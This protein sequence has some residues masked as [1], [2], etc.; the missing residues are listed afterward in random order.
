[1]EE[2]VSV[3]SFA[4]KMLYSDEGIVNDL[5]SDNYCCLCFH[6]LKQKKRKNEV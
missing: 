2:N 6:L 5:L 1:M 3:S 4:A